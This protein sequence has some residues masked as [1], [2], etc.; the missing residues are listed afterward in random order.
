MTD[1]FDALEQLEDENRN[2]HAENASLKE[3]VAQCRKALEKCKSYA[4]SA[5]KK[6]D[7]KELVPA[8][9]GEG[10]GLIYEAAERMI[11]V[12]NTARQALSDTA[13]PE[14]A[15]APNI[16]AELTLAAVM[17]EVAR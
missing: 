6:I 8:I 17:R 1:A 12:S 15:P 10:G 4:D 5:F 9:R 7:R 16:H 2:L 11:F 13:P 14:S 3:A